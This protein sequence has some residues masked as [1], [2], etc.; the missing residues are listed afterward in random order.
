MNSPATTRQQVEALEDLRRFDPPAANRLARGLMTL[1]EVGGRFHGFRFRRELGRGAF[2][3]VFLAEQEAM[4]G[5]P[6]ALK[7]TADALG[8]TNALS[9]LQHTNVVPIYSVHRDGPL[10]AVCMPYFGSTTLPDVIAGLGEG[11][12]LPDTG[13]GLLGTLDDRN[14]GAHAPSSH[15]DGSAPSADPAAPAPSSASWADGPIPGGSRP[16]AQ[17]EHLRRSNYVDAILWRWLR[18]ADGLAHAHERGILQRE[19]HGS[20]GGGVPAR[21]AGRPPAQDRGGS[22]AL[23]VGGGPL[24]CRGRPSLDGGAARRVALGGGPRPGLAVGG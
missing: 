19:R 23:P 7:V 14:A 17:I 20:Q 18:L 5:R 6:V 15:R 16:T 10:Q 9:Q 1:P 8:E 2:G 3:R 13:E 11:K 4:A 12:T 21:H 22:R 24:R